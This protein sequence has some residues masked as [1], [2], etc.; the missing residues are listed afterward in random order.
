MKKT[1][2]IILSILSL[3]AMAQI[4]IN[5]VDIPFVPQTYVI[6]ST[7]TASGATTP[8]E[9]INQ[10]WD[11]SNILMTGTHTGN[12]V[13]PQVSTIIGA[14][15][16]DTSVATDFIANT[17]YLRDNYMTQDASSAKIL[18]T[19]TKKQ[20]Y[21]IS[22][23]SGGATDSCKFPAQQQQFNNPVKIIAYPATMSSK[24]VSNYIDR[25][26]Y[27][28]YIPNYMLNNT[29]CYRISHIVIKDTVVGWGNMSVPTLLGASQPYNVLMVKQTMT[30]I[31]TFYI[32]NI[33]AP[34]MLLSVLNLSQGQQRVDNRYIF[35][36]KNSVIPLMEFR[37]GANN[38]TTPVSIYFD[39][40]ATVG[41]S[42]NST[43]SNIEIYPNP[44]S[45]ILYIKGINNSIIE[46]YDM[47]GKMV[48]NQAYT[49]DNLTI[50]LNNFHKGIYIIKIIRENTVTDRVIN[51]TR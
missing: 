41:I 20:A 23:M 45:D 8:A 13:N 24:W 47:T 46:I 27:T 42:E 11:Y 39:G 51:I 12:L 30:A 40:Q 33:L 10:T 7:N 2:F 14:T 36:R 9:G 5:E 1:V 43:N 21:N 19:V 25:V 44:A 15:L 4:T 50:N 38:F 31:D 37:F 22:S 28:L 17:V 3:N 32:N 16:A 29:P 6:V 49:D 18:G 26:D 48:Y 35:W 34:D